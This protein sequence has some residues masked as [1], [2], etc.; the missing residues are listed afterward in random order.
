MPLSTVCTRTPVQVSVIGGGTLSCGFVIKALSGSA[1]MTPGID[2]R[3][4]GDGFNGLVH[5][6]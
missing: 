2:V 1:G 4:N 5:D 3:H 6:R